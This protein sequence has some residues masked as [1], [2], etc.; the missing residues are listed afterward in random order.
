MRKQSSPMSDYYDMSTALTSKLHHCLLRPTP[1][2]RTL[3]NNTPRRVRPS[4]TPNRLIISR[5]P[6]SPPLPIRLIT[7]PITIRQISNSAL[8]WLWHLERTDS[9]VEPELREV[10]A[11]T[12]FPFGGDAVAF[13]VGAVAEFGDIGLDAAAAG[14]LHFGDVFHRSVI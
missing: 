5:I 11:A 3:T 7:T 12:Y 4:P 2:L 13:E 14:E 6:H 8:Q 9:A 1:F 10:V